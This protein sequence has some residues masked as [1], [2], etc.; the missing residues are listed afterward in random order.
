[1]TTDPRA[2]GTA[3]DAVDAVL[4]ETTNPF[5]KYTPVDTPPLTPPE[6]GEA[7]PTAG[8][9][10]TPTVVSGKPPVGETPPRSLDSLLRPPTGPGELG[11]I[12]DYRVT[13]ILGRGGM[14]LVFAAEDPNLGRAVAIK[15]MLPEVAAD[16][17]SRQRFLLEA[18]AAAAVEHENIIPIWQVSEDRGVPFLAMPLLSGVSLDEAVRMGVPLALPMAIEVARQVALGLAAAHAAGLIHRDI[19]PS[20]IWL[21]L[22]PDGSLRRVRLL[23]FGL[24][25][26]DRGSG[27]NL[28]KS[29]MILGTPA[30]MAPE[31]ARGQTLD[32]RADLFS[33]GATLYQM[34]TGR[35]PF[36][37]PDEFSILTSL[38]IDTPPSARIV[39]PKIPAELSSLI[40][41]LLAK[42]P[43]NRPASAASVAEELQALKLVESP[44]PPAEVRPAAPRPRRW[45][46][47]FAAGLLV[48]PAVA[49]GAFYAPT[50]IRVVTNT[51]E[52]VIECSDPSIDVIVKQDQVLIA[53]NP[54]SRR[55][56]LKP[57][58]GTLEFRDPETGVV[59]KSEQFR[60]ERGGRTAISV[61][62]EKPQKSSPPPTR[63]SDPPRT[64]PT[65][66]NP[67]SPP[68]PNSPA[69]RAA[70]AATLAMGG[71]LILEVDGKTRS[72]FPGSK[73]PTE[74]YVLREVQLDGVQTLSPES[75]ALLANL[76]VVTE[77]LSLADSNASAPVVGK[78]AEFPAFRTISH[79]NLANSGVTED[80]LANLARFPALTGANLEHIRIREK[81]LTTLGKITALRSLTLSGPGID[82]A[83]LRQLQNLKLT[84]LDLRETP[85]LTVS[86][87]EVIGKQTEL[88]KLVLFR[89]QV[90]D[91]GLQNLA[92]LANL[93]TLSIA[94]ERITPAGLDTIAK[95][96]SLRAVSLLG[97]QSDAAALGK[98]ESLPDL[99][100][101][102]LSWSKL[103]DD[104]L[105]GLLKLKQVAY[106]RILGIP[107]SDSA[108]K[109]LQKG[110]PS[111]RIERSKP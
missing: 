79:I 66:D 111:T 42:S 95:M 4:H 37:G 9:V 77:K 91:E 13:R 29:G 5:R 32:G 80:G 7:D 31:Q 74:S 27:S 50:I 69:A 85:N 67:T 92:G 26:L 11:R 87:F 72:V 57:G 48:L 100:A 82:T 28:T 68:D 60:I 94:G 51:G 6:R 49:A 99:A 24:A 3:S 84:G 78:L 88:R 52:L 109:K 107:L 90:S 34:T 70:L 22:A 61:T 8:S 44:V 103:T 101:L 81:G 35:R 21:E 106:L 83:G 71:K 63:T 19:K 15:V 53:D 25:R 46:P 36:T 59:V 96:R 64:T 2:V 16:Q 76:P 39:N 104:N 98:L 45:W 110:L 41:R 62:L 73:L 30:Y 14:G 65:V 54:K 17:E 102:D 75:V 97:Y 10:H 12:G 38:A 55:F 18:R 40:D 20:N 89:C 93:Q 43:D 86:S 47:A 108:V 33:L 56:V 105:D 58:A 23:D 1:M